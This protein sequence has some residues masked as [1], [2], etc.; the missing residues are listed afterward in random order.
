M[1]VR[2]G[3]LTEKLLETTLLFECELDL[4][5]V[6]GFHRF[7][8]ENKTPFENKKFKSRKNKVKDDRTPRSRRL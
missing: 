1:G 6:L 3:E 5:L 2:L 4:V 7:Q 8:N